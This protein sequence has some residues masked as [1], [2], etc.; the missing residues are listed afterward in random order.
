MRGHT[1]PD[2][3][4][5]ETTEPFEVSDP[6]QRQAIFSTS[7]FGKGNHQVVIEHQGERYCFCE[8]R[9]GK[10]ILTK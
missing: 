8:T 5:R 4:T 2:H 10:L 3:S 9:N 1:N 6:F 7:L